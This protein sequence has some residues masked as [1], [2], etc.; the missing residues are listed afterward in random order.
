MAFAGDMD[1]FLGIPPSSA[2]ER[3][4][5]VCTES[6]GVPLKLLCREMNTT[7]SMLLKKPVMF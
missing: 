6:V 1:T 7:S 3:L 5:G 4:P 2:L